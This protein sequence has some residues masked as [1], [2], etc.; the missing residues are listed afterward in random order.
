MSKQLLA[1]TLMIISLVLT[2]A[3]FGQ[4]FNLPPGERLAAP[5]P[6]VHGP[7]PGVLTA[8]EMAGGAAGVS[9]AGYA[10]GG[11]EAAQFSLAQV[12]SSQVMFVKPAGMHLYL[13]VS[14]C[15]QF[16]NTPLIVP[17]RSNFNP[18]SLYRLK[19]TNIPGHEGTEL[20]PSLEI[21]PRNP[22]TL[23]FMAHSTIPV[24][25]DSDDFNQI[26]AGN[27]V[28]KV[29]YLPDPEFQ[30]LALAGVETLVSTRL[31]PG[32]DP[33]VEADRRGV[34][35]AVVR[36]GNKD[37]EIPG[38]GYEGGAYLGRIPIS[39][40]QVAPASHCESCGAPPV[41]SGGYYP[42]AT[43]NPMGF[44]GGGA[45][46][47]GGGGWG[48]P[49]TGTPIGLPGPPHIPLGG[50]AGL[51]K[52][53]IHNRTHSYLPKPSDRIDIHVQQH[54]GQR[55]PTPRT[56]A[57]IHQYDHPTCSNCLGAGCANCK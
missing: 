1:A 13:D 51:Q 8:A 2:A 4:A 12:G 38:E 37:L 17:A 21:G 24:Q 32:L 16:V 27:F 25:L 56:R 53:T 36:V 5:G 33:I 57:W 50:P 35:L 43:A 9:P 49:I 30:E 41:A 18:G 10:D 55:Y 48:I 31:D 40:S 15:G 45:P 44:A 28:T 46:A 6:G 47:G 11:I 20:Y 39:D 22:R 19:L 42:G 29:I 7:G 23:A 54:P 52:H 34:I 14:G 3:C 26:L